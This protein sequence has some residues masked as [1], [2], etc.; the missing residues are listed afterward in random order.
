MP[1][2]R[3]LV[4]GRGGQGGGVEALTLK[5]PD[6]RLGVKG[7]VRGAGSAVGRA[8]GLGEGVD[9]VADD[10][11]LAGEVVEGEAGA[12]GEEGAVACAARDGAFHGRGHRRS[13]VHAVRRGCRVAGESS[14]KVVKTGFRFPAFEVSSRLVCSRLRPG[15]DWGGLGGGHRAK[16]PCRPV[17]C[18]RLDRA[19][20]TTGHSPRA[21]VA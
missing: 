12:A 21:C 8:R 11:V 9:K 1:V 10:K 5:G 16:L 2:S 17:E 19:S 13:A 14:V 4:E 3:R 20:W 7:M 6:Q 15:G 18:C